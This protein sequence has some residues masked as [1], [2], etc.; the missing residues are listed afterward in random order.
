MEEK[1]SLKKERETPPKKRRGEAE[2]V[3]AGGEW[4]LDFWRKRHLAAAPILLS[5]SMSRS[6]AVAYTPATPDELRRHRCATH[7]RICH[8]QA[9]GGSFDWQS[10]MRSWTEK[11]ASERAG[12]GAQSD[13]SP[14]N[15]WFPDADEC[16]I[17]VPGRR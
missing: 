8:P 10:V 3:K 7:F 6:L 1:M 15:L 9:A 17:S 14:F 12:S 16:L 2:E 4:E 13:D 11:G 5:A